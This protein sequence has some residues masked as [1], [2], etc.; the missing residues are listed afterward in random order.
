M[1]SPANYLRGRGT[2]NLGGG[3]KGGSGPS[4]VLLPTVVIRVVALN[5]TRYVFMLD[6][7]VVIFFGRV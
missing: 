2:V 7:C 3:I 1:S 6:D 5:L 4:A